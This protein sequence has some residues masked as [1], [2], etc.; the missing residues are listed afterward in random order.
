MCLCCHCR[1]LRDDL[2]CY[3]F[4]KL[5]FGEQNH[6]PLLYAPHQTLRSP[7]VTWRVPG[8]L[9]T[10]NAYHWT[11][12][13]MSGSHSSFSPGRSTLVFLWGHSYP[14]FIQMVNTRI[15]LNPH[16]SCRD[17][18]MTQPMFHPLGQSV[19]FQDGHKTQARSMRFNPR[20][21][22]KTFGEKVL[23]FHHS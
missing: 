4:S 23:C 14:L 8:S 5:K 13:S 11:M 9:G 10:E 22:A 15:W 6:G 2:D 12:V 21:F 18:Q 19:Y 20:I 7:C 16:P 1:W 17:R 3:S